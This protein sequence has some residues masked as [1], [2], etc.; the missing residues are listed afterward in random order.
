[1]R[2]LLTSE[3]TLIDAVDPYG[4]GLLYVSEH[5]LLHNK[6]K[7]DAIYFS[8][9]LIIVATHHMETIVD[10]ILVTRVMKDN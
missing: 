6:P 5:L 7:D 1:M 3:G 9:R 2:M 4:L 8:M 10:D